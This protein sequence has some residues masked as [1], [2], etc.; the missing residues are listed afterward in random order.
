MLPHATAFPSCKQCGSPT[1]GQQHAFCSHRCWH[2]Y[3]SANVAPPNER[4]WSKVDK[5]HPSGCWLWTAACQKSGYGAF[6][7]RRRVVLAHRFSYEL[8]H[9]PIPAGLFVCHACDTPA[10]VNPDHL[11]LGTDAE[12]AADMA[13][14]GRA[15]RGEYV[16]TAK[17]TDATVLA[18]RAR[19]AESSIPQKQ[20]AQEYGVSH[21]VISEVLHGKAWRHLLPS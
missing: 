7:I 3:R 18:I 10:C 4:F 1:K 21:S 12:N 8:A 17:L 11:W 15:S 9:G 6:G 19:W 5:S 13:S 2:S 16:P 20:L 14:K